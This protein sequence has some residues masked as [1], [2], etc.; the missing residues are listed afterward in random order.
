MYQHF[1]KF[2]VLL[3]FYAPWCGHCKKL[4]PILDEIAVSFENDSDVTIAKI[5]ATANDIPRETFDVKGYPTLYFISASGKVLRYEGG[6]TKD[7]FI[8]FIQKNRDKYTEQSS[9]KEEL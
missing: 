3:E 8:S 1:A 5:D 2:S 7:S 9:V 6:R 4:A